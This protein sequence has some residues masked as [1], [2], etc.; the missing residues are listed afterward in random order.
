MVNRNV[1]QRRSNSARKFNFSEPWGGEG[2]VWFFW[3]RIRGIILK[4]ILIKTAVNFNYGPTDPAE[5]S[6]K[7][8]LF[9]G[10]QLLRPAYVRS[11]A[12]PIFQQIYGSKYVNPHN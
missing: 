6:G 2:V 7:F 12:K 4:M 1:T 8:T 5:A 9:K 3:I 10:S 11:L